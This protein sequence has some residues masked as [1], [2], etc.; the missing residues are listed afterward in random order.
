MGSPLK[1]LIKDKLEQAKKQ[2]QQEIGNLYTEN[3]ELRDY[4]GG[5]VTSRKQ[6]LEDLIN[7][8]KSEN[9]LSKIR[10]SIETGQ[11]ISDEDII[12]LGGDPTSSDPL[13]LERLMLQAPMEYQLA[14]TKLVSDA[15]RLDV[16]RR[17]AGLS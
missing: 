8:Q 12:A 6:A 15:A 17:L 3:E 5:E 11:E 4:L 13:N 7:Q 16:L 9:L 2:S 14:D 10:S 1:E